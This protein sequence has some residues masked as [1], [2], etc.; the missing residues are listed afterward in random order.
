[1][2]KTCVHVSGFR[3]LVTTDGEPIWVGTVGLVIIVVDSI[4][5]GVNVIA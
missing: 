1:M 4:H 5:T 2:G 3:D